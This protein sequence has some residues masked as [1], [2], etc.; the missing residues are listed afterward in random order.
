MRVRLNVMIET[1]AV[2]AVPK[3]AAIELTKTPA[4]CIASS[5]PG[6]LPGSGNLPGSAP[7]SENVGGPPVFVGVGPAFVG[8]GT[9]V[10]AAS[11]W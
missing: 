10:P 3:V 7:G 8:V 4:F 6:S 2:T 5:T 11:T 1:T 9:A